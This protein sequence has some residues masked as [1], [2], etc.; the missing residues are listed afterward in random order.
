[1]LGFSFVLE[2]FSFR[3]AWREFK[4][5]KGP[6]STVRALVDARDPTIPVVLLEDTAALVGLAIALA[7]VGL[8]DLTGWRGWDG[9]ASMLIGVLLAVVAVFLARETHSLILGESA[10][11][12]DRRRVHEIALGVPGVKRITQLLSMHRGPTDVLLAL[13]VAF[14]EK[15]TVAEMEATIDTVEDAIRK[16]LPQMKQIFI[17]PDSKYDG[18]VDPRPNA[19]VLPPTVEGAEGME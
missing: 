17:E 13:K 4:K 2:S 3:V 10:T 15:L 7:G 19:S 16:D 14:D 11:V 9:I 12:E 8:A 1:V 18:V 5:T 6:R